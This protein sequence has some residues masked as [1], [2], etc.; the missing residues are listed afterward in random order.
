MPLLPASIVVVEL[1][2]RVTALP[3]DNSLEA[4]EDNVPPDRE[5]VP[6]LF[7]SLTTAPNTSSPP[8]SATDELAPSAKVNV[9]AVTFPP[10]TVNVPDVA[11]EEAS[12]ATPRVTL[13]A[14][15][16]PEAAT[17]EPDW[18]LIA[19][20]VDSDPFKVRALSAP[21][22]LSVPVPLIALLTA[23]LPELV[24]TVEVPEIDTS[25]L[26]VRAFAATSLASDRVRLPV[27][28]APLARLSV[29]LEIER[30][31]E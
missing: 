14:V 22:L 16:L 9:E 24:S 11:F 1:S 18:T 10:D 13:V 3:I 17:K 25:L 12:E 5:N 6:L 21:T 2:V 4:E 7:A 31:P 30:A 28:K 8:E 15:K 23:M 29:L 20:R 26:R 27:P 19:A